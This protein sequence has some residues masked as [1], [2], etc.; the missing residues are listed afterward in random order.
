M[1]PAALGVLSRYGFSGNVRHL[2]NVVERLV[3]VAPSDVVSVADLPEELSPAAPATTDD[4]E[5]APELKRALRD[6]E[7]A[8]LKDALRRYG[9]QTRAAAHLGVSQATIARHA[10]PYGLTRDG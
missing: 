1:S 5:R 2:W 9:T 7:A 8:I 4:S 3:V 10:K 6:V